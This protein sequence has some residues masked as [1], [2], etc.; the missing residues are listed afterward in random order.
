ML[1]ENYELIIR[2][3]DRPADRHQH[4]LISS[5]VVTVH[6]ADVFTVSD[7]FGI[8]RR[9][10]TE[11]GSHRI[12]SVDQTGEVHKTVFRR[13]VGAEPEGNMATVF[14]KIGL[15]PFQKD[16]RTSVSG[17]TEEIVM[18]LCQRAFSPPGFDGRLGED[19]NRIDFETF[20]RLLSG[21]KILFDKF[22]F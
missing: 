10:G 19:D 12:T 7:L 3:F 15:L 18:L 9:M 13:F 22:L 8:G 2:S 6:F 5:T 1:I 17:D 21:E 14:R 20:P 4:P 11:R 16:I